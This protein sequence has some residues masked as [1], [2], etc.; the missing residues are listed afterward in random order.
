MP[1]G[2]RLKS[3]GF[4]S[5]L[6]DPGR[7]F[8][9]KSYCQKQGISYADAGLPVA[10]DTFVSYGLAFQQTQVPSLENTRVEVLKR[11]GHGFSLELATGESLQ[12]RRVIIATGISHFEYIPER[13]A[14]LPTSLCSHS[15][16]RR[17]LSCFADK[18]VIVVGAG[19][20]ATDVAASLLQRGASVTL[21]ARHDVQFHQH[22]PRRSLW[23]R[24][25]APNLGLGP[26]L[27]SSACVLGPDLF[28]R[29][30][31]ARRRR[32][33]KRHLG[34]AGG[35]F[36]RDEVIGRVR[37]HCGYE[38]HSA[39]ANGSRV[40]LQIADSN[41]MSLSLQADH[42]ISATGYRVSLPRL[43]FLEHDLLGAIACE[44][45]SPVLS[46]TFESSVPGLY[47][48]GL[49]AALTF[50]PLLRFALGARFASRRLANHLRQ[51]AV[52]DVPYSPSAEIQS[53]SRAS[54]EIGG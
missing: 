33:V 6:Y 40:D 54:R 51:Y 12:A 23:Q 48:V 34:P 42:I 24:I 44:Y 14:A 30:P 17:D 1:A 38:L 50:G 52:K 2:M 35:W 5:D 45:E 8:T 11:A 3:D 25:T 32:I 22:Q 10:L 46:G 15:S 39:R 4:A 7:A 41:G 27:R 19:S 49:A 21:V 36:V 31:A 47:F 13:L 28:R 29:L 43:P 20:S 53:G 18:E 26:N 16:A 9:L 37:M